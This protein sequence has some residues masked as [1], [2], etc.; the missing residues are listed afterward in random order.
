MSEIKWIKISTEIFDDEKLKL[1][2]AMSDR[3]TIFYVWI[4]LLVQA[5][6][7]NNKGY[8]YLSENTSY[9]E[10][11]LATI[12]NRS[13]SVIKTALN[14]LSEFKMIDIQND[15]KIKIVNWDKH[16]NVEG[17][18]RAREQSKL[19]MRRKRERDKEKLNE[20]LE[21]N[22][23]ESNSSVTVN[24]SNVTVTTQIDK[25]NKSDNENNKIKNIKEYN[26]I[27]I[28]NL[29][30]I[31]Q[32]A[33]EIRNYYKALFREDNDLSLSSLKVA[34]A[35]HQCKYVILAIEK[36]I[37]ANKMNMR[38]INGILRNWKKEGY[39]NMESEVD[40]RESCISNGIELTE[41]KPKAPRRIS[42]EER[43]N[44]EGKLI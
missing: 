28:S 34:I 35:Q 40:G 33:D 10:E 26:K 38:Y 2:D 16:Q 1:I 22:V 7:I 39:P 29:D 31:S 17:M 6:K 43:E 44:T 14:I 30:I 4:R 36:S 19:R 24:K 11:M 3:D 41:F 5:G 20:K 37:Q 13:L 32:Q 8:V 9:D 12:F 18:E 42:K 27:E 15:K 23:T 25:E 21:E